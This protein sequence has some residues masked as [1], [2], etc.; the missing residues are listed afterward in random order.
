MRS[1]RSREFA[2]RAGSQSIR[3]L[4]KA[5]GGCCNRN[6]LGKEEVKDAESPRQTREPAS[7][8]ANCVL[9]S[10]RKPRSS[11]GTACL[12]SDHATQK[13]VREAMGIN[14]DCS[15]LDRCLTTRNGHMQNRNRVNGLTLIAA[16]R[17]T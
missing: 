11:N 3:M 5:R 15:G 1:C 7:F 6:S 4:P 13:V 8:V 2:R 16:T 12:G 14:Y 10:R 17:E 9:D